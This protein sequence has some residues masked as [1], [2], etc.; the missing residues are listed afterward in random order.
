MSKHLSI[1]VPKG[2]A[3]V[4]TV[5][6][7]Y[8]LFHM[9]NRYRIKQGMSH[10]DLFTIDLVALDKEPHVFSQF[11]AIT[12]TKIIEQIEKTDLIIVPGCGWVI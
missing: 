9:A 4:D 11:M 8:N 10:E 1:L 5:I 2:M 3:I 7:S 6:G 12:P